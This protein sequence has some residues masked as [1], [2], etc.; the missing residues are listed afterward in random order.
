MNF[1]SDLQQKLQ[2]QFKDDQLLLTAL[3]HRS[4]LNEDRTVVQSNERSEFLGDAVLELITSE[5]LFQKYP[6]SPEG[7]LTSLRAKIVQTRTLATLATE[8]GIGEFLRMSKGERASGGMTNA[9]L[10]ADTIEAIIGSMYLDSGI[11]SAKTFIETFLLNKYEEITKTAD[12]E[13][14]KSRL[15][16][17]IQAK[18]GIAPTYQVIHEEGPDHDRT[19]TIQVY[20][21]DKPQETGTGK[22]KQAA[23]QS[24]ARKALEKLQ[25]LE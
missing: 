6:K 5:F 14:W 19:F 22:S 11:D 2:Y 24:A 17:L 8:L 25:S 9:S 3:T 12:V 10:L 20:Y 18:G 13:D 4:F 1:L 15:Q 23:Q 16:E 7:E 21:L